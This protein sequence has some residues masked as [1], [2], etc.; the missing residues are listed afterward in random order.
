MKLGIGS[1][2]GEDYYDSTL[3]NDCYFIVGRSLR[4]ANRPWLAKQH[5]HQ[6]HQ[7]DPDDPGSEYDGKQTS[8]RILERTRSR[9]Y[10][11]KRKWR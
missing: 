1:N 2:V 10:E 6:T 3:P 8:S 9:D 4:M 5:R 11:R 7:R